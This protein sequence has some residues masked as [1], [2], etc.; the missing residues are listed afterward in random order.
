MKITGVSMSQTL[1]HSP[2]SKSHTMLRW[3]GISLVATVWI[4]AILF[5]LYI[6]AFYAMAL[7]DGNMTK[8]NKVLPE[9]YQPGTRT[10]TLGIG[11]HFAAGGI[12]LVLG[13]IQL[14]NKVRIRYPKLHRWLGRVYVVASVLAAIGG[15]V[16]IALKGT[17]GGTVMNIGFALYG[18][19]MLVCAIETIRQAR[20]KRLEAHRVWALRLFSLAIGSWLYR[21]DYGF[22]LLL[23]DGAGHTKDFHGWFDQV[24]SFFFYLPNLIV[25]ELFVRAKQFNSSA[26]LRIAA[27][28]V[29]FLATAFLMIGTY[30]FTDRL[31]GPA[32]VGLFT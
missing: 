32:I 31:W 25:V 21:M 18:I 6:L 26:G 3:A 23:A 14:M 19:L 28:L 5:G 9:I 27:A 13:C 22:W 1:T 30:F 7:Y 17:I 8:W 2:H 24:M 11:L 12:I 4:S 10:A 16:F 29:L 15:L 20:A